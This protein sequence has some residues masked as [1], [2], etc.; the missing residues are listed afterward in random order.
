MRH[1]IGR[2]S[3]IDATG[4]LSHKER[5]FGSMNIVLLTGN[6]QEESVAVLQIWSCRATSTHVGI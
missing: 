6:V 1:K 5:A 4:T 2:L 3:A